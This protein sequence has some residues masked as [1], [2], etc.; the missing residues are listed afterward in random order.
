MNTPFIEEVAM[1][2]TR[3]LTGKKGGYTAL[4]KY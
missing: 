2:E 3:D 1:D 4:R